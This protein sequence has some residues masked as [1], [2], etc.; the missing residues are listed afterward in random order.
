ML[1]ARPEG[2]LR[3]DREAVHRG[4][5]E[6]RDVLGGRDGGSQHPPTRVRQRNLGRALKRHDGVIL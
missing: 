4:A 2:V 6:R 3:D 1:S 5:I